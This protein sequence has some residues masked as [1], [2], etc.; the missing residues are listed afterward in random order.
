M[1]VVKSIVGARHLRC[2]HTRE[3]DGRREDS[4]PWA[5]G[6]HCVT[7]ATEK[8]AKRVMVSSLS[9]SDCTNFVQDC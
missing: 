5:A 2:S 9:V 7:V 1:Q 3:I 6:H 8:A 4:L